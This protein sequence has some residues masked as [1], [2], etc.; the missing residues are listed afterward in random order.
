MKA[1]ETY[2]FNNSIIEAAKFIN[3]DIS[4]SVAKKWL[5]SSLY[6][7]FEDKI[8]VYMTTANRKKLEV[9]DGAWIIKLDENDFGVLSTKAFNLVCKKHDVEK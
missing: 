9:V 1:P 2:T 7:E 8:K 5:G 3:I 4:W 6:Y